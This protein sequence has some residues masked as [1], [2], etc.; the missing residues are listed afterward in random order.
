MT[1]K[2]GSFKHLKS[3]N[4]ALAQENRITRNNERRR[5]NQNSSTSTRRVQYTRSV[6]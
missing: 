1:E 6:A 5:K 2:D 4:F 3:I